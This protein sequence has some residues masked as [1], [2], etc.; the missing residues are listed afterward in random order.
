MLPVQQGNPA[1][2]HYTAPTPWPEGIRRY[3]RYLVIGCVDVGIHPPPACGSKEAPMDALARVGGTL[4]YRLPVEEAAFAGVCLIVGDHGDAD[5]LRLVGEHLDQ[6]GEGD[7]HEGLV[8]APP[9]ADALLPVGVMADDQRPNPLLYQPGDDGAAGMV[10]VV[11][12]PAVAGIGQGV[13]LAT[14]V[15]PGGELRLETG[16]G[17]VIGLVDR[18]QGTTVHQTR[19]HTGL[20]SRYR[21]QIVHPQIDACRPRRIHVGGCDRVCI[22]H[23]HGVMGATRHHPHLGNAR[24]LGRYR[25]IDARKGNHPTP[26]R[27]PADRLNRVREEVPPVFGL[28]VRQRRASQETGRVAG[29]CGACGEKAVPR[30]TDLLQHPLAYFCGKRSVRRVGMEFFCQPSVENVHNA[31]ENQ[32]SSVSS[33]CFQSAPSGAEIPQ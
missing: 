14:R 23:L 12:H 26:Q 29:V 25:H 21:H 32:V 15:A 11:T 22:D 20:G 19:C 2:L 7:A 30:G 4:A 10:Q 18:F 3:V 8:G 5:Q 33:S 31:E 17:L 1:G 6:A 16:A 9:Q 24:L 28:V 27:H 13:K